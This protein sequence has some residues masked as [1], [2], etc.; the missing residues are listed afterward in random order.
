MEDFDFD[1]FLKAGGKFNVLGCL[2]T[3]ALDSLPNPSLQIDKFEQSS[4]HLS[5]S[6][7]IEFNFLTSLKKVLTK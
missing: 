5:I 6:Q 4:Q 3:K 2:T 7:N 1:S